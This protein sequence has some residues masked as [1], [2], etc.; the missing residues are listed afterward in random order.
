MNHQFTNLSEKIYFRTA[1]FC[2]DSYKET[3]TLQASNKAANSFECL[4]KAPHSPGKNCTAFTWG[5]FESMQI[6]QQKGALM[7]LPNKASFLHKKESCTRYYEKHK[8]TGIT[9]IT[10]LVSG[11]D[12]KSKSNGILPQEVADQAG[13][14]HVCFAK[15]S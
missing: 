13:V 6:I 15:I 11:C 10:M 9:E 3:V 1:K 5:D 12:K 8:L 7:L 4:L 14:S 2:Q